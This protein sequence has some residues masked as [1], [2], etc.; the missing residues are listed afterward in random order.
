MR[1][2]LLL[3][4]DAWMHD[5][6]DRL[7]HR[8]ELRRRMDRLASLYKVDVNELP[9]TMTYAVR[10]RVRVRVR[11]WRRHYDYLTA[12]RRS[13]MSSRTGFHLM[14][15]SWSRWAM[16]RCRRMLPWSNSRGVEIIVVCFCCKIPTY[17][18]P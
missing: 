4:H 9:E 17:T 10:V 3:M 13:M 2:D 14:R 5:M 8:K 15:M 18:Q 11:V 6:L 1:R 12:R 16:L 7:L